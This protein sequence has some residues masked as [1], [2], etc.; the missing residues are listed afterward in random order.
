LHRHGQG[1]VLHLVV[2]DADRHQ[3]DALGLLAAQRIAGEQVVL[4][5][6]HAAQ[7]RPADGG[8]VAGGHAQ[9]GV[10]VDDLGVAAHH[11][12]VGQ[13]ARHQAGAHGRAVDGRH[14]GLGA[15]DDVEHQVARLAH[16]PECALA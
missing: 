13:E 8:V 7:Q 16:D 9:P 3:A 1:P 2:V 5:L 10:A 12:H 14:D 6:G 15:V 11:R 4:G